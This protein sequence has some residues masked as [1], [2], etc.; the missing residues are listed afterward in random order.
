MPYVIKK[1]STKEKPG[2][3]PSYIL[4]DEIKQQI[5]EKHVLGMFI[6]DIQ[7]DMQLPYSAVQKTIRAYKNSLE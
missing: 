3:K 2:P 4:T 5:V 6:K 7:E 1:P